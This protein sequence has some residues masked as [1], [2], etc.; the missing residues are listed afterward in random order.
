MEPPPIEP[1]ASPQATADTRIRRA[2]IVRPFGTKK[3]IDFT[4][5]EETLISPALDRLGIQGRTTIEIL[6]AGNIRTDMFH[7]LLSADIV[8]ADISIHNANVFYELGVRHSLRRAATVMIRGRKGGDKIPFD[9]FTDRYFVYDDKNPAA[10]LDALVNILY[11]TIHSSEIDSPV[12]QSVPDLV[13]Q[14]PESFIT[15]PPSFLEAVERAQANQF[16]GDL[17]LLAE[18]T[19]GCFW[20]RPGLRAVARAEYSVRALEAARETW[21]AIRRFDDDDLEAN[22]LL[23]TIYQKLGDLPASDIAI[24]RVLA[25][26]ELSRKARS[27]ALALKGRNAKTR[28]LA[29]WQ[30]EPD[31]DK[32]A[33]LALASGNLEQSFDQYADGFRNDLRNFYAGINALAMLVIT[34]ELAGRYPETWANSL[35]RGRDPHHELAELRKRRP[36]LTAAVEESIDAEQQLA[37]AAGKTDLWADI[38]EADLSFYRPEPAN[39]VKGSYR[40]VAGISPFQV[41]AVRAQLEMFAR[42]GIYEEAVAAALQA[43][44]QA[45]TGPKP[46]HVLLFT[47]HRVDDPGRT[48]PRFPRDKVDAARQEI[49]AAIDNVIA[50][51]GS[52]LIGISGAASGGDIL[53]HQ[54]CQKRNIPT[55]IFLALPPDDYAAQ[56]VNSAGGEWT[57]QYNAL[58]EKTP[59]RQLQQSRDLPKWL[60][61]RPGYSVWQRSNLWMLHNALANG[62]NRV[63]LIALWNGKAGDGPGGTADMVDQIRRRGGVK[64][65][66]LFVAAAG[67]PS[68]GGGRRGLSLIKRRA[69]QHEDVEEIEQENLDVE[70]VPYGICR[71]VDVLRQRRCHCSEELCPGDDKTLAAAVSTA[72]Q[73]SE[74]KDGHHEV[75]AECAVAGAI[76]FSELLRNRH[77]ENGG[78]G[79]RRKKPRQHQRAGQVRRV[80]A[81]PEFQIREENAQ[82][83]KEPHDIDA[84]L[85]RAT[86]MVDERVN[87]LPRKVDRHGKHRHGERPVGPTLPDHQQIGD[88]PQH[89]ADHSQNG[90]Q[91]R[92]VRQCRG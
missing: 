65:R 64:C 53:F 2:F 14:N 30:G 76:P 12:F 19:Q 49:G 25:L 45:Q 77:N 26:P 84:C 48:T 91:E 10:S 66:Y 89:S 85:K 88:G 20:A 38:S 40:R 78:A 67:S 57:R 79:E 1:T 34:I 61:Q 24:D 63:T 58:L 29:E 83:H 23:G 41:E 80:V 81:L 71:I 33:D 17:A 6:N 32:A 54:E 13:E 11:A 69:G 56:S 59:W 68:R 75:V 60:A 44:P 92:M 73:Q 15:V 90:N 5:V 70:H 16:P 47:G 36:T 9:L 28:W 62:S 42:L 18:E 8:I 4:A 21:E 46:P 72:C 3:K 74:K 22:T 50:H 27:E 39:R 7:L 37:K 87:E 55:T 52:Q 86:G 51:H 31:R 43:L 82:V 35:P